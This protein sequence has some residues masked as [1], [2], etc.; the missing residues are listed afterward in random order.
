MLLD[1]ELEHAGVADPVGMGLLAVVPFATDDHGRTMPTESISSHTSF[2]VGL[3]TLSL[4]VVDPLA[5]MVVAYG[6]VP[7]VLQSRLPLLGVV[8][9]YHCFHGSFTYLHGSCVLGV[10]GAEGHGDNVWLFQSVRKDRAW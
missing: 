6:G 2:D 10:H 7:T 5:R 8:E 3:R 9:G 4:P 1:D